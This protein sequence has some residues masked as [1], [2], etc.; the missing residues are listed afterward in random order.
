MKVRRDGVEV[1]LGCRLSRMVTEEVKVK[2]VHP[3]D[4][5]CSVIVESLRRSKRGRD[6]KG[7]GT[8]RH[9]G[10]EERVESSTDVT[11]IFT[12]SDPDV[13]TTDIL[14]IK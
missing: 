1:G 10:S 9:S 8:G 12:E 6:F 5:G 4:E 14:K 7:A 11:L 13:R 3:K 2:T